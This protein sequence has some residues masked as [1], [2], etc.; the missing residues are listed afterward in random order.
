M[1]IRNPFRAP[2]SLR[3]QVSLSAAVL[4]MVIVALAGAFI[5]ARIHAQDLS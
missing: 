2:R 3:T 5:A 1:K 4:V